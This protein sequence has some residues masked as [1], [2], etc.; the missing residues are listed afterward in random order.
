MLTPAQRVL[1]A[2]TAAY[3]QH[4]QGKTN[5]AAAREASPQ[6]LTYWGKQ[7]DPDGVLSDAERDKRAEHA[8]KAHMSRMALASSKARARRKTVR[9]GTDGGDAA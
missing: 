5:T 8:R 4:A 6:S 7:V 1:R 3:A 2:R 9:P